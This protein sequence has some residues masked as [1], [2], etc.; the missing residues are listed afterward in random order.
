[1]LSENARSRGFAKP[2]RI[3]G[4]AFSIVVLSTVITAPAASPVVAIDLG[5]LG[6]SASYGYAANDS[7]TVVGYS[8][9]AG[10]ASYHAFAWTE[11]GGM[12]DLGTLGG[13][14]S[15]AWSVDEHGV[16][17]GLSDHAD[18]TLHVF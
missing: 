18:S 10:N 1:M 15:S 12:K 7:G 5:T 11:S 17:Y 13:S 3:A 14:N 8:V 6:G 2:R 9:V 4:L 16:V